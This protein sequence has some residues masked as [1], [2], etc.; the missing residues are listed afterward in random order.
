VRKTLLI[1]QARIPILK[2]RLAAP[3]VRRRQ[4]WAGTLN[5]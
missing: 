2:A 5:I 3:M 1:R 4:R